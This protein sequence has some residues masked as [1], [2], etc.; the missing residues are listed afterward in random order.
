M[1]SF[2]KG[3]LYSAIAILLISLIFIGLLLGY[4]K[5]ES[6][7]PI[8]QGCPDYWTMNKEGKCVNEKS[9]GTCAKDSE[10]SDTMD[11]K[12]YDNCKKY[13]WA[14]GCKV[15]WDGIT[16]GYGTNKPCSS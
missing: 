15:A 10:G 1:D 2:Q 16:Y 6:W 13:N 5:D 9:L 8:A 3:V 12:D 7:P 4:A 11:F 14:N